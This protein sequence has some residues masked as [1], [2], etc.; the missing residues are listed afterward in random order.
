[1]ATVNAPLPGPVGTEVSTQS[2][3]MLSRTDEAVMATSEPAGESAPVVTRPLS[4]EQPRRYTARFA[5]AYIGLGLVLAGAVSAGVVVYLQSGPLAG[6]SWSSWKPASGSTAQVTSS[7]ASHVA[8]EYHLNGAGAQLVGVEAEPLIYSNGTHKLSISAVAVRKTPTSNTGIVFYTTTNTWADLLCGLGTS[9]SIASG[10]ATQIRGR[11]VRRE[12]LELALYTFKF[13]PAV[14]SLVA[15]MPPP[16]GSTA[17]TLLYFQKT[18]LSQQLSQ[19]LNKTLPL[20]K[21]P[22]PTAADATEA[23]TI[24]KLTLPAVYTYSLAAL[25]DG[26]LALVLAP[27]K[28]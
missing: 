13:V 15:Y 4:F 12:A 27:L 18:N 24:D 14:S 20:V 16:P 28:A 5:L 26:S 1:M 19:P 3:S 25:Q 23:P 17:S 11:L 9:C 7:I 22:L 2:H 10:Q 8:Q 6:P 21:P